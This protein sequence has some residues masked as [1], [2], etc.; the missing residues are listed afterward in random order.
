[1]NGV[2]SDLALG[3]KLFAKKGDDI[4][5]KGTLVDIINV[6]RSVQEVDLASSLVCCF[7]FLSCGKWHQPGL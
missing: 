5:Y 6:N 1:M 7:C 3:M 2:C 4:W